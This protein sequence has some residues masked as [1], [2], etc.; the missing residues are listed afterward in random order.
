MPW[1]STFH[2]LK[3]AKPRTR[4][5]RPRHY[6]FASRWPRFPKV[7]LSLAIRKLSREEYLARGPMRAR[8][9]SKRLRAV[10]IFRQR[11]GDPVWLSEYGG[12]QPPG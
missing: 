6:F 9:R 7:F 12:R 3:Y 2:G 8:F 10:A 4:I 1:R 5:R 11:F